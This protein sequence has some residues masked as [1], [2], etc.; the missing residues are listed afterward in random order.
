MTFS[1]EDT[2]G[3]GLPAVPLP[4]AALSF[5]GVSCLDLEMCCFNMQIKI[6]RT[7]FPLRKTRFGLYWFGAGNRTRTCTAM[8]EEPKSTES[9]NSTMPAYMGLF[10]HGVGRLS[11]LLREVYKLYNSFHLFPLTFWMDACKIDL[12]WCTLPQCSLGGSVSLSIR[13]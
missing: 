3:T 8:P 13:R 5:L 12:V 11:I 10:Y 4:H 2:N 9:T 7:C 1:V 6:I